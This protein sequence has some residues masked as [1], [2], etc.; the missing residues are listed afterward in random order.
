MQNR[1]TAPRPSIYYFHP[2]LGGEMAGWSRHLDRCAAMGFSHFLLAPL[3]QPGRSGNVFLTANHDACHPVLEA[4]APASLQLRNL[5]AECHRREMK[6][7]LDLVLDRV[8]RE[9]RVVAEHPDWFVGGGEDPLP[10]PRSII[11]DQPGG[12]LSLW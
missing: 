11:K 10:D 4:H 6:L 1:Q 9:A 2:T 8:A 12:E 5:A 3:F 7:W